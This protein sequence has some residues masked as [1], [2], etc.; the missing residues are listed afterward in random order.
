MF[1]SIGLIASKTLPT[2]HVIAIVLGGIYTGW[3][4]AIEAN[5]TGLLDAFLIA[6]AWRSRSLKAFWEAL[7]ETGKITA[8]TF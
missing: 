5:A 7:L 6:L 1:T 2:L 3:M 8:A 4:T